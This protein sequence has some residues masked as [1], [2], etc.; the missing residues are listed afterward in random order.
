MMMLEPSLP[1]PSPPLPPPSLAL[2]GGMVVPLVR[3]TVV[4]GGAIVR[5]VQGVSV[6]GAED[7]HISREMLLLGGMFTA[8]REK[9]ESVN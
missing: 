8:V 3:L 9:R 7:S 6:V 4:S 2:C 1:P 5:A